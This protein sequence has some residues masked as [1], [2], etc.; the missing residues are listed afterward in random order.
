MD[1]I[2]YQLLL[3]IW[4]VYIFYSVLNFQHQFEAATPD[5]SCF[6]SLLSFGIQGVF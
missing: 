5:F 6:V 3:V 4:G 2:C 1:L